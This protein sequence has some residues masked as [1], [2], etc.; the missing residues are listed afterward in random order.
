MNRFEFDFRA[1]LP[2]TAMCVM[3]ISHPLYDL[4][5]REDHA[6]FFVAHDSK[7]IDIYLLVLALSVALPLAIFCVL[8]MAKLLS[9]QLG[10]FLYAFAMFVLFTALFLP[11]SEKLFGPLGWTN[12][13]I[14]VG[15]ALVCTLLFAARSW[16]R[17]VLSLAAIG[18]VVS[19]VLFLGNP[20]VRDFL[21]SPDVQDY[22][23]KLFDRTY[24]HV[25]MI[26][27]D[28][29]PLVSLL[30]EDRLIDSV[31]FPNFA[32]LAA[33]STWYRNTVTPHTTT[34]TAIPAIL[35]GRYINQSQPVVG[36][37]GFPESLVSHLRATH[38]LRGVEVV[39][40]F[41]DATEAQQ[42]SPA[43]R[44]RLGS[45]GSDVLVLL[46]HVILPQPMVGRLPSIHSQWSDFRPL[47]V[48]SEPL[49]SD[50]PLSVRNFMQLL[51][52][53]PRSTPA[54]LYF[55]LLLPH[56]PLR[57][58]DDGRNYGNEL[59]GYGLG[60]RS[61]TPHTF[62][63]NRQD[64]LLIH[65]AHLL[66]TRFVDL[67]LGEILEELETL[68]L[69]EDS[70]LVVTSD[71]G[72]GYLWY[73]ADEADQQ[74]LFSLRAPEVYWVPFFLKMPGQDRGE[75][76]DERVV[77][78][79]I[80]PTIADALGKPIPWDVDGYSLLN[81]PD[82]LGTREG[83]GNP[84]QRETWLPEGAW[85]NRALEAKIRIFGQHDLEGLY[86]IGPF[87]DLVG[88]DVTA[89]PIEDNHP[90][91]PQFTVFSHDQV[92]P[93]NG[94]VPLYL[95]GELI[96]PQPDHH[97]DDLHLAIAINGTIWGTA[98]TVVRQDRLTFTMRIPIEAW[99]EGGNS[100]SLLA[101]LEDEDEAGM[102][103]ARLRRADGQQRDRRMR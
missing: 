91:A 39:T 10:R 93:G 55:H 80:F 60:T 63:S 6:T 45:L 92:D 103:L 54:F 4:L 57:Y 81:R 3:A 96:P 70:L 97:P 22:Q 38:Q 73:E 31:R 75:V 8:W 61:A 66:Q 18:A 79:D 65:Q 100:V 16:A 89:L 25:V 43:L 88:R 15:T 102:I 94:P 48:V 17:Q 87:K 32:R 35:T 24:P 2:I 47:Q 5:V 40:T 62:A 59:H 26:V 27:F 72:I 1:V 98:T 29:F 71:H 33:K 13:A 76:V 85:D 28:E 42:L 90:N 20:V 86:F 82:A 101:I 99:S 30:D 64:A 53:T 12:V 49:R 34:P 74:E 11:A 44:V 41:F 67:I 84:D 9:R 83:T 46:G 56:S 69:F 7:A 50:R 36:A 51:K 68:G 77:T 78:V 52:T 21:A 19:P 23:I 95:K 58:N 37:S 14:A